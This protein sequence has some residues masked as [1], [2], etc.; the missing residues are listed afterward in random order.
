M[1]FVNFVVSNA[2][3]R[4]HCNHKTNTKGNQDGVGVLPLKNGRSSSLGRKNIHI[5]SPFPKPI[6]TPPRK[7]Q[8]EEGRYPFELRPLPPGVRPDRV[9]PVA[10]VLRAPPGRAIGNAPQ[11]SP[12]QPLALS[13]IPRIPI[14]PP[15]VI[16]YLGVLTRNASSKPRSRNPAQAYPKDKLL[17]ELSSV[18][19]KGK[20]RASPPSIKTRSSPPRDRTYIRTQDMPQERC[21]EEPI[22]LEMYKTSDNGNRSPSNFIEHSKSIKQRSHCRKRHWSMKHDHQFT[23]PRGARAIVEILP[24]I[25]E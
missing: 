9:V 23:R 17:Q 19:E 16:P 11:Y 2:I 8:F 3:V 20:Q 6:V 22:C 21:P 10:R 5:R 1:V 18:Q 12:T 4:L 24:C 15:R 25:I 13:P 14:S 7:S